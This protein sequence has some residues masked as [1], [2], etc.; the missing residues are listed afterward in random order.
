MTTGDLGCLALA[1]LFASEQESGAAADR[2]RD[3][4]VVALDEVLRLVAPERVEDAGDDECLVGQALGVALRH[5]LYD[6]LALSAR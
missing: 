4:S 1:G 5:D 3:A 2:A 6:S